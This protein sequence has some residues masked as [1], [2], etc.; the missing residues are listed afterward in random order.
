MAAINALRGAGLSIDLLG[1]VPR[2]A[3]LKTR[4][5][6][7]GVLISPGN[8]WGYFGPEEGLWRSNTHGESDHV[9]GSLAERPPRVP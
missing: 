5:F 9:R 4:A 2:I 8:N 6:A 1:L 3:A 7:D